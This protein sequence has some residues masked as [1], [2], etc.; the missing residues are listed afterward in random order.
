MTVFTAN[1]K[2]EPYSPSEHIEE[3]LS[4]C[5]EVR[6]DGCTLVIT[7]EMLQ[8]FAECVAAYQRELVAQMMEAKPDGVWANTCG[9]NIR[10]LRASH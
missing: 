9:N 5:A 7:P 1:N 8:N 4:R 10:T 3:W 6:D 2:R